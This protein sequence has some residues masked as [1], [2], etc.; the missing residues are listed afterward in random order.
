MNTHYEKI[1]GY[2]AGLV[3]LAL[4]VWGV[5]TSNQ[6]NEPV[7]NPPVSQNPAPVVATLSEYLAAPYL[8]V[9]ETGQWKT[10]TGTLFSVKYP[11]SFTVGKITAMNPGSDIGRPGVAFTV[12]HSLSDGTNL[13][14]DSYMSVEDGAP[15]TSC[16]ATSFVTNAPSD[17]IEKTI[18]VNGQTYSVVRTADA[19]AGNFYEEIAVAIPGATCR[20]LKLVIHST[21]IGNYDPGTVKEFNRTALLSTFASFVAS[22]QAQ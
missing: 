11:S 13:S 17:T 5:A 15:G 7:N 4:I 12:P 10:Y 22:Y 16:Q 6:K 9:S 3:V 18:S 20:G 1:I 21:N 19:G 2:L 14:S 8:P